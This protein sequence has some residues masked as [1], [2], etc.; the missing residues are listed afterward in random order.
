MKLEPDIE[1]FK[2]F[3]IATRCGWGSRA[4][5]NCKLG[6]CLLCGKD[7]LA[8]CSKPRNPRNPRKCCDG[9]NRNIKKWILAILS[10]LSEPGKLQ[11]QP[12]LF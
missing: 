7:R 9:I 12:E 5:K 4:P 1:G 2:G 8:D 10:I 3:P 11:K 6:H